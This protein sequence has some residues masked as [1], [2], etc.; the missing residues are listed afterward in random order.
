MRIWRVLCNWWKWI[1]YLCRRSPKKAKIQPTFG[2][3]FIQYWYCQNWDFDRWLE[4]YQMLQKIGI[5]EVIL[6]NIADTKSQYA[7]Y[8]TK[9]EGYTCNS[10]DMVETALS[11]A[12]SIGMYVRIGL[13]YSKDWWS[14][15]IY[16]HAWLEDEAE[17]NKQIVIEIV[18]M[19]GGHKALKGWYIPYEFHPLTA[20][21]IVQQADLNRF[22]KEIA[23]TIKANS[24]QDIM[25]APYYKAQLTWNITLASWAYSVHHI[26]YDTGIDILALQDSIGAG[27]NSLN[28]L[29]EIYAYTRKATDEI[30]M[31]LFA[32]TETFEVNETEYL[33]AQQHRISEQLARESAYVR[34]FV[35]FSINHYQNPQEAAQATGYKDYYNY[36]QEHRP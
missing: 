1:Y 22:F 34:G 5:K 13:G 24:A 23:N 8:P 2:S 7:V 29:D 21:S 6:Q 3:T 18:K 17:V 33:P 9:M 36:Y 25:V 15:D 30:G 32:V 26:L 28:H 31:T 4:E 19:Y 16:E 10:I 35:A 12:D 14:N 11:A 27:F 20:L